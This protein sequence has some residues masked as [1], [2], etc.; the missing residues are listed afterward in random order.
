M[1]TS[2]QI[3]EQTRKYLQQGG[4]IVILDHAAT[5]VDAATGVAKK[6]L[7]R[8]LERQQAIGKVR[9]RTIQNRIQYEQRVGNKK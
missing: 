7:K 5:G 8:H 2:D 1:Y 6:Y 9:K 4:E 3:A